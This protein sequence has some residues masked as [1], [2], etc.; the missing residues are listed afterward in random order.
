LT[1]RLAVIGSVLSTIVFIA[2]LTRPA[3]SSEW[4]PLV[5]AAASAAV[6]FIW[7]WLFVP[8]FAYLGYLVLTPVRMALRQARRTASSPSLANKDEELPSSGDIPAL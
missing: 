6:A 4:P 7:V 3:N 5:A 8:V 2:T 1:K